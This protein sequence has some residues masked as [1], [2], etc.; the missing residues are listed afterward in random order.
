MILLSSLSIP[1][2][3]R[4]GRKA[5]V[6][7]FQAPIQQ[8]LTEYEEKQVK[9]KQNKRYKATRLGMIFRVFGGL[10]TIA[11]TFIPF[12]GVNGYSPQTSHGDHKNIIGEK[13]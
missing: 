6:E 13:I 2:L 9:Q 7:E 4:A 8:Q 11:T 3:K 10:L 5:V 12:M 1:A